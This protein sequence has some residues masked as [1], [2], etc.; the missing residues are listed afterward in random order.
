MNDNKEVLLAPI[1]ALMQLQH[2]TIE[3]LAAHLAGISPVGTASGETIAMFTTL[4]LGSLGVNTGR[5]YATHFAHLVNGVARQCTCVCT[6]C[7]EDFATM[8][9]C[10]CQCSTCKKAMA[11]EA[12]GDV[13]IT[14]RAAKDI[15][16]ELLVKLVQLMAIKRAM[17]DN[18]T[19]SR[20]G[21]SA[22]PTHGQGAREMCVT[23]MRYLFGRMV[24]R[25]LIS[26]SPADELKKGRRSQPRRRALSDDELAQVFSAVATGGD[27]PLLDL[28][29]TWGEFELGARRG[30]IIS[31]CVGQI[32]LDSQMVTLHEK[33]DTFEAKP[34]SRELISFLLDFAAQRGGDTCI[35]GFLLALRI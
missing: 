1:A 24:K 35:P 32:D 26:V 31:L 16:L 9:T 15:N 14:P 2:L 20:G 12:Q 18:L 25:E 13:V 7:V 34:C 27:D 22:K 29:L 8:A 17:H 23:A 10:Q 21:L 28:A 19:R 3:D 33:G 30:G 6:R 5:S 4:A 11:F